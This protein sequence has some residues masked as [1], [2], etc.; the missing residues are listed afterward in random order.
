MHYFNSSSSS[1]ALY[2]SSKW[3][4][5][6]IWDF[7]SVN[8]PSNLCLLCKKIFL[9]INIQRNQNLLLQP[10]LSLLYHSGGFF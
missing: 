6:H 10:F 3:N 7:I 9:V 8:N 2:V 4:K 5:M 1:R